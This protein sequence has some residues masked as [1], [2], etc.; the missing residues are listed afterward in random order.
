MTLTELVDKKNELKKQMNAMLSLIETEEREFTEEEQA[1]YDALVT[2][3]E[4]VETEI[5][6][7]EN[8]LRSISVKP[9][10]R[11][12]S[13]LSAIRAEVN[14]R[15]LSE[16]EQSVV[17][18]GKKEMERAN[19][20][21]SGNIVL[22]VSKRASIQATVTGAGIENVQ[23]DVLEILPKLRNNLVL[24]NSGAMYLPGLIGNV[25]IPAYNGSNVSWAAE[26]GEAAD[27]G[28]SFS[29]VT[30]SP[31]RLT[32]NLKISKQFLLQDSHDAEA[33]LQNDLISALAE[34][35][36]STLLGASAGSSTQPAGLGSLL[37][38]DTVADYADVV[39]LEG[40]LE[41]QNVHD[42]KYLL[43]PAMKSFLRSTPK[44]AGNAI[45]IYSDNDEIN[46]YK[47]L[48]SNSVPS[49]LG[50]VGNWTDYVVAQW[51][52][53]DV[54]VDQYT[55]ASS[56]LIRLVVNSYWDGKPRRLTSFKSFDK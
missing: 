8:E 15:S 47:A 24:V 11:S 9:V 1:A 36:E 22:P 42:Y 52:G 37:T 18:Q 26:N 10:R 23:T 56:G 20:S 35:L 48:S 7:K 29:A 2:E 14:R 3:L 34:K 31:K 46:G 45:F 44:T 40:A 43:S 13:L 19:L 33:I 21:F 25:Q 53:I 49:G 38:P 41:A 5:A 50:F 17:N 51:G 54:V 28:G 27:A 39:A 55:L 32:A 30:Y 12:F 6:E 16:F 4:G